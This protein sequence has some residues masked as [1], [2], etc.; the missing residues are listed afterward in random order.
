LSIFQGHG[1]KRERRERP[2]LHPEDQ[3]AV[4]A[5]GDETPEVNTYTTRSKASRKSGEVTTFPS[6]SPAKDCH[7]LPEDLDAVQRH[8]DDTRDRLR[9]FD[10]DESLSPRVVG[11]ALKLKKAY[12]EAKQRSGD[13]ANAAVSVSTPP[14][15]REKVVDAFSISTKTHETIMKTY[16]QNEVAYTSGANGAGRT[17]NTLAKKSRIPAT[18]SAL[19]R[20]Q[21]ADLSLR[22]AEAGK[23]CYRC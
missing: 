3:D 20:V 23:A 18:K 5:D 7:A 1:Q 16:A 11:F 10:V 8:L 2:Q 21:T 12:L 17:G 22:E 4:N 9:G 13:A 6:S 14:S 15:I 19:T